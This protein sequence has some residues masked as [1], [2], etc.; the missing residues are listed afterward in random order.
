MSVCKHVHQHKYISQLKKFSLRNLS[1]VK[2][3]ASLLTKQQQQVPSIS[4]SVLSF[5][6]SNPILLRQHLRARKEKTAVLCFCFPRWR[7]GFTFTSL[8]WLLTKTSCMSA[9]VQAILSML[10]SLRTRKVRE[11]AHFSTALVEL[12]VFF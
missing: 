6:C 3:R 12:K 2:K 8:L 10:S 4:S 9:A 5:H 7:T 11:A 1:S